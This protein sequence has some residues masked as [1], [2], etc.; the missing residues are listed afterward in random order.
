MTTVRI[1]TRV[2]RTALPVL[3]GATAA[4]GGVSAQAAAG[5]VHQTTRHVPIA[6]TG[7]G[8][9]L[10]VMG[11]QA[12]SA[13]NPLAVVVDVPPTQPSRYNIELLDAH[14]LVDVNQFATDRSI[15]TTRDAGAVDLPRVSVSPTRLYYLDGDSQVRSL[16]RDGHIAAVTMLPGDPHT[17]VTFAVSPDDRRIAVG[18]LD[19]LGPETPTTMT[20]GART[21]PAIQTSGPV[22]SQVYVQDLVGGGHRTEIY[23]STTTTVT[24][25]VEWPVGWRDGRLILGGSEGAFSQNGSN[26]PT[27]TFIGYHVVDPA[28]GLR[29]ATLCPTGLT[30]GPLNM[31][32]V[33]CEPLERGQVPV[34]EDWSGAARFATPGYVPYALSPDGRTT[35]T[36]LNTTG[37]DSTVYLVGRAANN[38]K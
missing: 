18:V 30:M 2:A 21:L 7:A 4:W 36:R 16:T 28:T 34:V 23:S 13:P 11:G 6:R 37:D 33:I 24:S 29:T 10:P 12:P 22:H 17:H 15:I 38:W 8:A 25:T 20:V 31:S 26:S 3:L 9:S 1:S 32:G 14:G 5:A 35:A 27:G 19:Y